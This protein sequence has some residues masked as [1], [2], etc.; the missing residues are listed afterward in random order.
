[1][2]K[3]REA[4]RMGG[5]RFC[6]H[7]VDVARERDAFSAVEQIGA[8]TGRGQHMHGDPGLVHLGKAQRAEIG[9]LVGERAAEAGGKAVPRDGVGIDPAHQRRDVEMLLKG[10]NAHGEAFLS[11]DRRQSGSR[12]LEPA[13]DLPNA[14]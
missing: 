10:D 5:D 8:G 3:A 7:V 6:Q 11:S 13:R 12:R 2:R 1:M 4:I 14:L 9:Q